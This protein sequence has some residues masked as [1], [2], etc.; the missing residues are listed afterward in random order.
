MP[1][2]PGNEPIEQ[3]L[4]LLETNNGCQLPCWWGITPGQTTWESAERFFNSF[5]TDIPY[6]S[7]SSVINYSP[8]IPLPFE[9]FGVD[10]LLPTYTVRDGIVISINVDVYVLS[11]PVDP[12]PSY[13]M[14]YVLSAFLTSMGQ[15][16]EVWLFTY[17]YSYENH[18]PFSVVLFYRPQGVV[19]I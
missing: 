17:S 13:L 8:R 4:W 15:P 18:V 10:Y 3:V 9:V 7:G 2:P 5:V 16:T 12:T 6:V 11:A 1:T 19:A 14:P